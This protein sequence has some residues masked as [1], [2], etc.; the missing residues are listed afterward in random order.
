VVVGENE[1]KELGRK[2]RT[3]KAGGAG[4]VVGRVPCQHRF[5]VQMCLVNSFTVL[6]QCR[7][8]FL[9]LFPTCWLFGPGRRSLVI[10]ME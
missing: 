4:A 1:E 7:C 3:S 2:R 6:P 8:P 10:Q 5:S 9:P